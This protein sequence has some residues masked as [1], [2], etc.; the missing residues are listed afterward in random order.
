MA[1]KISDDPDGEAPKPRRGNNGV[2]QE[3][4]RD[5]LDGLHE[6]HDQMESS[7][8]TYRSDIKESYGEGAERLDVPKKLLK[9]IFA[10]ERA[11]RRLEAWKKDLE[12]D[13]RN[14]FEM[15]EAVLVVDE[16]GQTGMDFDKLGGAAA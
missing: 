5:V 7:M 13:E 10:A 1:K 11:A 12:S 14:T 2:D 8:G 16:T 4:L 9:K 15:M 6:L 3:M